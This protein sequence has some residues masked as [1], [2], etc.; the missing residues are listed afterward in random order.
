[1]SSRV[2][3]LLALGVLLQSASLM[4]AQQ[5]VAQQFIAS[6]AA[7][8]NGPTSVANVEIDGNVV[9]TSGSLTEN[10]TIRIQAN[11][12]GRMRIDTT[13]AQGTREEYYSGSQ[14]PADCAWT[15]QS[16]QVHPI[17]VHNCLAGGVSMAPLIIASYYSGTTDFTLSLASDSSGRAVITAYPAIT[18]SSGVAALVQRSAQA[19]IVFDPNTYLPLVYR[20]RLHPDDNAASNIPAEV[21]FSNYQAIGGVQVPRHIQRFVNGTLELDIIV[22]N[23]VLNSNPTITK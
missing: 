2:F 23:V 6:A 9:H 22:N 14:E 20:Y 19:Q 4:N 13:Y 12:V 7:I 21:R 3:K 11:S 8:V 5:S 10:G 15:D 18:T 17:A 1:M 16:G